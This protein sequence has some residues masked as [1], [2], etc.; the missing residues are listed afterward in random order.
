MKFESLR[1]TGFKTFVEPCDIAIAPGLTGI[2][3]PNGCGKSNLVEA[4]RWVMGETSSKSLRGGGMED[5]I[6]AGSTTRPERNHAEVMIRISAP[7]P[8]LPRHLAGA[9]QLDISRKITRDQGSTYRINGREVRARD[10]QI[11]FADAASGARSPALVRQGQI[12]EIIAAK[13][14]HRRRI[15]EDAAGIGGL[16]ARRHEAELRLK[17]AE[18]NLIR[19]QDVLTQLDRQ[20][21]ELKKQARQSERYKK[22]SADIRRLELAMF[23]AS[24]LQAQAQVEA[25][26]AAQ[27][28][29][30][31]ALAEAMREQGERERA[32]A[33]AEHEM[34]R[35]RQAAQTSSQLVQ[36]GLL[37]RERLDQTL[38]Q[39]ENRLG[40]ITIR[41]QELTRDGAA[42]TRSLA[43]A[44]EALARLGAEETGLTAAAQAKTHVE[45]ALQ[46]DV[47]RLEA[48]AMQ[49]EGASL[50]AQ[51]A[52]ARQM[53]ERDALHHAVTE[54]QSRASRLQ[55]EH[56]QALLARQALEAQNDH[57][58]MIPRHESA[59]AEASTI[60]ETARAVLD[61]QENTLREARQAEQATRPRLAEAE[62]V[63]QRLETEAK[64]IRKMIEK[65]EPGL[66]PRAMDVLTV[67]KGYEI[68][69]GAALGDDLDAALDA[70]APRFWDVM[71]GVEQAPPA[72]P[73]GVKSLS[74]FVVA[75]PALARR[76]GQIGLVDKQ[77]GPGLQRLLAQGQRLVSLEGD[78][79]RWDG[80]TRKAEAPSSAARRLAER[81]RLDEIEREVQ[82]ARIR[83]DEAR[84]STE[85]AMRALHTAQAGESA[86][87]ESL[88]RAMQAKDAAQAA[89]TQ[90]L[91]QSDEARLRLAALVDRVQRLAADATE[92]ESAVEA[93]Q[94]RLQALSPL[95]GNE[96]RLATLAQ[97]R[98][99]TRERARQARMV[100]EK[101]RIEQD[102]ATTR[103]RQIAA[104]R[105]EWQN[106]ITQAQDQKAAQATR[107]ATLAAEAAELANRPDAL[108]AQRMNLTT[109]LAAHEQA[110]R[111]AA[112]ALSLGETQLREADQAA[113]HAMQVLSAAREALARC[114]AAQSH[115]EERLQHVQNVIA[116]MMDGEADAFDADSALKNAPHDPAEIEA[117]LADLKIERDKLGIVNLR[118]DIELENV[119]NLRDGLTKERAE[120]T[121]AV[122]K[123]RRAIDSLNAEG[124]G[125][126]KT[127]FVAVNSHFTTLF[128]RLFGGGEA[129]LQ[130]VE[131][132]DP[133]DAGL[134]IIARPPGKKPQLLS[135]LSGG[136]QA[137]TATAL[138]FAVF[139]TN[140]SPIC[141]LDEVDAPLD[142]ANVERLCDLL[143][144]MARQTQTRFLIITH[145]P[146]SMARMDRLYGV[147]MVERGMSQLVSV[148]LAV[149]EKLAETG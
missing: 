149:A 126:L 30:I 71:E 3:G 103:L 9:D 140:P 23:A 65:A 102:V 57:L 100:L 41:K 147:T 120:I 62:R 136:E 97:Q 115:A 90:I 108:R 66:W 118:A 69:L 68:A 17:A 82:A 99:E 109:T 19:A 88:R 39:V 36:D 114:E 83:R 121:E 142:D 29:A 13:P 77:D 40:E 52:H 87:R 61:K 95:T 43:D 131:A 123:F 145:N 138:I 111:D 46:D 133:L 96:D 10:V 143:Q 6:F 14:Q 124:R 27:E 80:F 4:L 67:S 22:L 60:V 98:A 117:Q 64:T 78:V 20:A 7:P 51:T 55:A 37:T 73:V 86:A 50:A 48:E 35:L 18:D 144:D 79:W 92:A 54:T 74:A 104:E 72:L 130:L 42:A 1:L 31:R 94:A 93:A 47:T 139:L 91:R 116:G 112:D 132:D 49:A 89:L 11:L 25:A 2:V 59:L 21:G 53:A 122:Q 58:A 76:L 135:L 33:V 107:M 129:E 105:E 32:R 110:A 125:R 148:D 12:A 70:A 16:H 15:L 113:R 85:E 63:F 8:D 146:I 44:E 34:A 101:A 38:K 137:L 128:T 5:V 28:A 81:N 106:R 45:S 134:E 141:V 127:A 84:A 56:H 24:L 119:E 26:K 75:P